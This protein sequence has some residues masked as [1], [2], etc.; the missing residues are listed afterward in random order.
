MSKERILII[1]DELDQILMMK[2]RLEANGYEV[3]KAL[4]GEDG[5]E[6]AR[7]VKP[8]LIILDLILPKIDGNEVCRRLKENPE[9]KKIP[10]IIITAYGLS[11]LKEQC[12]AH[13][14]DD[15]MR[16]P[17]ISEEL[18][19]KIKSNLAKAKKMQAKSRVLVVDDEP[20]FLKMIKVRLEANNYE[21]ITAS[22]GKEAIEKFKSEKPAMVLLDIIMP[23]LDGIKVLESIRKMNKKIPVFI[24]TAFSGKERFRLA[25]QLGASGIIIK[26]SDLK[27]E[28]A[29]LNLAL[30]LGNKFKGSRK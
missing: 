30:G 24:V 28:I 6:K 4:D 20:D 5:L 3:F 26:T 29:N 8:D 14:A 11:N 2:M 13:G 7:E 27:N 23:G 12:F 17:Y 25:N 18:L 15:C 19:A 22:N 9:T 1:E 21:V 16:K 10:V